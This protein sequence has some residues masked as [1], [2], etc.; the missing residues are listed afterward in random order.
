MAYLA[1]LHMAALQRLRTVLRGGEGDRGDNPV[2]TAIIIVG[3]ALMAG[4][5]V[6]W[7]LTTANTFMDQSG[8]IQQIDGGGGEG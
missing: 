2:P 4:I 8:D 7:A 3:L 6:A 1:Y 5:V